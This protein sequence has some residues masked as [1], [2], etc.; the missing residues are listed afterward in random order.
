LRFAV[1]HLGGPGPL[2]PASIAEMQRPQIALAGGSYGLGWLLAE[3]RA[4]PTV[5]H[6][7]SVLGFQS[8]LLL[9]PQDRV[10]VAAL[11][12]SSRGSAAI[13]DVLEHLGLG[14][15]PVADRPLSVAE[16]AALTGRY[17]GQ[18]FEVEIT[19]E[20]G[21]LSVAATEVDPFSQE[22]Q[23]YPTVRA[24]PVGEREFEIPDGEWR[25]ERFDFPREGF[26]CFL[27]RLAARTE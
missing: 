26:V 15:A 7:G 16:L 13:R 5:E 17:Q 25:G 27:G 11:T 14:P 23:I 8:L 3:T 4:L 6:A 20:D 2:T 18:N 10:A 19:T 21:G 9:A 12:N 1:H 22:T 24:R